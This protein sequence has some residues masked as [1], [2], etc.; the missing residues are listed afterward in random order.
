MLEARH[1]TK[2]YPTRIDGFHGEVAAVQDVNI[3]LKDGRA[4]ALVGESGSGKSTLAMLLSG[5][6]PPTSGDV[7]LNG[8]SIVPRGQLRDKRLCTQLQLVLQDGKSAL[9]PK[10]SVYRNIAEPIRN[11]TPMGRE[12]EKAVI[13]RLA[14]E[15]E[16]TLEE[17]CRRPH[18]LSGGQQKRA[19]IARALATNPQVIIFD[20]AVSGLDVLIRKSILDLLKR[21][22]AKRKAT[23]LVITHDIDVALYLADSIMIMKDGRIIGQVDF[24]GDFSCFTHPYSRRLLHAAIS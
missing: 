18:E 3:S 19:C 11:L 4:Y 1:L 21:I 6:I 20:E 15:A 12:A 13:E 22:Q 17:L 9:D 24:R 23:Y 16:L 5:L 2:R 14:A 7:T 10:M 8:T